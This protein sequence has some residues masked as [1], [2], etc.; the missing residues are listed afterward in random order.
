[1]RANTDG[2][3][4][5]LD[6]AKWH[7]RVSKDLANREIISSSGASEHH[8]IFFL[9]FFQFSSQKTWENLI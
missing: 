2:N 9:D 7:V 1:M 6:E 4:L 3:A 8:D 5:K